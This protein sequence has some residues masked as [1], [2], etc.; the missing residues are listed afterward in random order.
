MGPDV[1]CDWI[2]TSG[3]H[4]MFVQRRR[5][6]TWWWPGL[7]WRECRRDWW[8]SCLYQGIIYF[9]SSIPWL[10]TFLGTMV[11]HH[12]SP[13]FGRMCAFFLT[14]EQACPSLNG[15]RFSGGQQP[16]KMNMDT[17]NRALG[18]C[19]AFRI[20]LSWVFHGYTYF[21]GLVFSDFWGPYGAFPAFRWS[22]STKA[23]FCKIIQFL[24]ALTVVFLTKPRKHKVLWQNTE[25]FVKKNKPC[26]P[27]RLQVRYTCHRAGVSLIVVLRIALGR[28]MEFPFNY[29]NQNSPEEMGVS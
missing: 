23:F 21:I 3:V 9:C 2:K 8:R 15:A 25:F 28:W 13:P 16:P 6:R 22:C 14:T 24:S 10:S 18:K 4:G 5:A 27:W 29:L 12:C 7:A 20:W 1:R 19:I 17:K 26:T 11:N